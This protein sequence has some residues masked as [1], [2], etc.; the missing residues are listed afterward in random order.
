MALMVI[1]CL[2]MEIE[3]NSMRNVPLLCCLAYFF[4]FE[5]SLNFLKNGNVIS[6]KHLY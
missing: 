3:V 5:I 1:D 2:A 4:F 6:A